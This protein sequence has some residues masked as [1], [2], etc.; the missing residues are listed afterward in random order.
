MISKIV[1]KSYLFS[2]IKNWFVLII[3]LGSF[4]SILHYLKEL[5]NISP[6]YTQSDLLNFIFIDFLWK[7]IDLSPIT[8]FISTVLTNW[9]WTQQS[10]WLA[11]AVI[12]APRK[13]FFLIFLF[14]LLLVSLMTIPLKLNYLPELSYNSHLTRLSKI[15]KMPKVQINQVYLQHKKL[16]FPMDQNSLFVYDFE[17]NNAKLSPWQSRNS[18][19]IEAED[20]SLD[21][22]WDLQRKIGFDKIILL[23]KIEIY[24]KNIPEIQD[25]IISYL[26]K[27]FAYIGLILLSIILGWIATPIQSI[28]KSA[29]LS[30]LQVLNYLVLLYGTLKFIP[31]AALIIPMNDIISGLSILFFIAII[32][33]FLFKRIKNLLT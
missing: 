16:F 25:E 2:F 9:Q 32:G 21:L 20:S 31:L 15:D 28:K 27:D 1:L 26:I 29:S 3:L 23:N 6:L 24:K 22:S 10:R 14:Q 19:L 4:E 12:G 18:L 17:T 30:K 11:Y 13:Q 8:I 33:P 7:A 5:K